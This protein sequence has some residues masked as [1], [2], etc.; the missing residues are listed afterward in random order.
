MATTPNL[1]SGS[2]V[3]RIGKATIWAAQAAG[4]CAV[5]AAGAYSVGR[6]PQVPSAPAA[7]VVMPASVVVASKSKQASIVDIADQILSGPAGSSRAATSDRATGDQAFKV[8]QILRHYTKDQPKADR[9][10]RALVREGE[11]HRISPSLLVGVLLTENPWLDPRAKSKVGARG[12]MQVMPFHSGRWGC[13]SPDLFDIE[14]NI[15]HGVKILAQ[16]LRDSRSLHTALLAYNGCVRGRNTPNC[17]RYSRHVLKYANNS[18]RVIDGAAMYSGTLASLPAAPPARMRTK[19]TSLRS[20]TV[21]RRV[22]SGR[23]ATSRRQAIPKVP[24][25]TFRLPR[26]LMV[27]D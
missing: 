2:I 21:A 3:A 24:N 11:K 5:I 13:G 27:D 14:S 7:T 17:H 18:A 8:S 12:L 20:R 6:S 4:L 9:I 10:A 22:A 16:N 26:E 1:K 23:R 15:C 25:I 19:A